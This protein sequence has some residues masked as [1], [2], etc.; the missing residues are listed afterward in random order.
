MGMGRFVFALVAVAL[1]V[2]AAGCENPDTNVKTEKTLTVNDV[3]VHYSGDVSMDQAK[4]LINFV[5]NYFD[6]TGKTDIYLEKASGR[7]KVGIVTPYNSPD[8]ISG[9]VKFAITLAASRLSQEVFSGEPVTLQYLSPDKDVLISADGKYR[10]VENSKIYVWYSGV[11]QE[12]AQ[13]VLVYLVDFAGQGPWDVILE[14]SGSTYHV[15]AMSSF[16]TADEANSA[17][18]AYTELVSGLEE[19][20]NGN[21]VLHVLDPNGNELTTFGP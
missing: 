7:Y 2:I 18:D 21:V 8:E 11:S 1:L 17:K 15:R 5:Y 20:L 6:I 12:E 14:K 16:T 3:T 10:Y 4:A 19:R 9:Q 13:K